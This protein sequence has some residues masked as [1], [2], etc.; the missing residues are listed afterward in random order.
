MMDKKGACELQKINA[1]ERAFVLIS[2]PDAEFLIAFATFLQTY[3]TVWYEQSHE[4]HLLPF[5]L[6]I[7]R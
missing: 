4:V 2:H 6:Q 1:N 7:T 5:W 3:S